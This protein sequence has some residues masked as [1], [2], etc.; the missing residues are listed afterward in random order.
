MINT[1]VNILS[2]NIFEYFLFNYM[3]VQMNSY[4]K[5]NNLNY[6]KKYNI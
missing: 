3:G 2:H 5:S 6:L 4:Q 1:N